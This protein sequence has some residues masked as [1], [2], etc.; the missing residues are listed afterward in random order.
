MYP[1]H[2][3]VIRV[4][5]AFQREHLAEYELITLHLKGDSLRSFYARFV[6]K[7]QVIQ[8]SLDIVGN[9]H[10]VGWHV[11][12]PLFWDVHSVDLYS[13]HVEPYPPY[14]VKLMQMHPEKAI[15]SIDN[16][17]DTVEDGGYPV[18]GYGA[19]DQT[20]SIVAFVQHDDM[21]EY[22]KNPDLPFGVV[23]TDPKII[24]DVNEYTRDQILS[25]W[26][27]D[28]KEWWK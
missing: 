1:T 13:E 27:D 4:V 24:A 9:M 17:S 5:T 11:E 14:L 15:V 23:V 12:K 10:N 26:N 25:F 21:R 19:I 7:D 18:F 2:D 16:E 28:E 20:K 22:T 6:R 8:L 3:E